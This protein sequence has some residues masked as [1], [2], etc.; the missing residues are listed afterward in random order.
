MIG[1]RMKALLL[2]VLCTT[3]AACSS[4]GSG[5]EP[6]NTEKPAAA[7]QDPF[8]RFDE[9][10][11]ISMGKGMSVDID[12]PPGDSQENNEYVRYIENELNVKFDYAWQTADGD[13]Y[14][15]KMDL[16]IVSGAVPDMMIVD[17]AQLK[18]LVDAD[19]VADL[20]EVYDA[21]VSPELREVFESTQELSLA[22]ATFDGKLMAIPN[23]SPGADA[24]NSL[25][26]RKDW[27]DAVGLP[28]PKTLE[29]IE[30][31]AKAFIANDLGGSN[32]Q[33]IGLIGQQDIVNVGNSI[34]GFDT[35]FS[36]YDAYP[37]MW[38]KNDE[39]VVEY[40]SIQPETKLALAK[41]RDMY[42]D[43]IIHK[44][45]VAETGGTSREKVIAG[46]VGMFFGP[47]WM[48][49]WLLIDNLKL[50]PKAEWVTVAVPLDKDG[51]FK[52]HTMSPTSRY[53]AVSK[54]MENPEAI[55]RILNHEYI[56]DQT[57][58]VEFYLDQN[59]RYNRV[60]LPFGHMMAP[61]D[62][63]EIAVTKVDEVLAGTREYETLLTHEKLQYDRIV[64]NDEN[65]KKD[66]IAWAS[67]MSVATTREMIQDNVVKVT[68]AFYGKTPT[69][70]RKWVNLKKL[71]DETFIQIIMGSKPIDAFDQF[72][73]DWTKQ[74]GDEITKEVNDAVKQ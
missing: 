52:T 41:L 39:G 58:G 26:I 68:G 50:D 19:L 67:M 49:S 16:V 46:R 12:L 15:Q 32:N 72:V 3:L 7:V 73:E 71:E 33:T 1:K 42:A 2:I 45:F 57:R 59:V 56:I 74:G 21:N 24:M 22:S 40:G 4:G 27:L 66:P 70:N 14:K 65:P 54:K 5:K 28:I 69:M 6:V 43:G 10:V 48:P 30:N 35:I 61:F 47:F 34:F 17:E 51:K 23:S 44:E 37:E 63:K 55:I 53:L 25:F 8:G 20:T 38:I 62:E 29:D 31:A 13:P 11:T 36:Y 64:Y 9:T 18:L 60:N